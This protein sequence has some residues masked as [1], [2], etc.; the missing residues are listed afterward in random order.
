MNVNALSK[1]TSSTTLERLLE[2]LLRLAGEPD[3]QVGAEREVR[4]RLPQCLDQAEVALTVVCPAHPLEDPRRAR[5]ERQVDVLADGR[6]L[7]HRRDHGLAEVLR[8]RAREADALDSLD[9]VAC[10][11]Q[12][13]EVGVEAPGR[14]PGPT[15]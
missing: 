13:A 14:G 7:G 2:V 15:S 9:G 5:L 12:L 4:D 6:A 1:R 8:V 10:P 11:E 3:D